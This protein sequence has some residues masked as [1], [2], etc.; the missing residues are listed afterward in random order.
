MKEKR[1]HV[2]GVCGKPLSVII[3]GKQ[4]NERLCLKCLVALYPALKVLEKEI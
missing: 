4:D 1:K 2:C 3:G